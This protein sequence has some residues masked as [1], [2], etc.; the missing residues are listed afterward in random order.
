MRPLDARTTLEANPLVDAP[1][2]STV[3]MQRPTGLLYSNDNDDA[4][5]IRL[6][7]DQRGRRTKRASPSAV[8]CFSSSSSSFFSVGRLP[9]GRSGPDL[10]ICPRS[11]AVLSKWL[12]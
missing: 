7:V 2:V 5:Q 3:Q 12:C 8:R 9:P 4:F 6:E 1:N 11:E 10:K